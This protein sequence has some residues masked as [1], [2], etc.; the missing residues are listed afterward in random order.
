[1]LIDIKHW[2]PASSRTRIRSTA[3]SSTSYMAC[4]TV[5]YYALGTRAKRTQKQLQSYESQTSHRQRSA[6]EQ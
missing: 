4:V 3:Q 6:D 2:P 1:M 5:V